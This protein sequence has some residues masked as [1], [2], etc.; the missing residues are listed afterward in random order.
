[1]APV[2]MLPR[3][4][5]GAEA[6]A[7]GSRVDGHDVEKQGA[8]MFGVG[9]FGVAPAPTESLSLNVYQAALD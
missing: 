8:Q 3:M 6:I 9:A 1:M 7:G 5:L 4:H 2:P